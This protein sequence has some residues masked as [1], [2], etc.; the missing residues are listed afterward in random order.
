MT[1]PTYPVIENRPLTG[2]FCDIICALDMANR[3]VLVF[4]VF[5]IHALSEAWHMSPQKVY[6]ILNKSKV[7]D[8]YLILHYDVLHTLGKEYLVDD[9]TGCV[10]DWGFEIA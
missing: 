4:V 3:S 8:N 1:N 5:M 6:S 10:K 2:R 7:L 9:V